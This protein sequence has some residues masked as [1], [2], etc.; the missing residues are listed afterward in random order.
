MDLSSPAS[1]LT[2]LIVGLIGMALIIYAKKAERPAPF[3]GGAALCVF[4]YF[5]HGVALTWLV[6]ALC[7]AGT[8]ALNR[9]T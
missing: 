6:A 4:P 2:S 3:V 7:L 1:F 9:A 5:I 8:W